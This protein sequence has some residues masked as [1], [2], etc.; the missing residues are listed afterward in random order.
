MAEK[1]LTLIA[2][3]W[4]LAAGFWS[5]VTG[6]G[7]LFRVVRCELRVSGCGVNIRP[8]RNQQS[9]IIDPQ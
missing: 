3:G 1:I 6:C 8:I 7:F 4:S 9:Q 2:G 5:L